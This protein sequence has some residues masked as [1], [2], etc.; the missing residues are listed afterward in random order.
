MERLALEEAA[1][2]LPGHAGAALS[3]AVAGAGAGPAAHRPAAVFLA[4]PFYLSAAG[5]CPW[6]QLRSRPADLKGADG[7]AVCLIKEACSF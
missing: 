7:L 2:R 1:G 6:A 3:A 4:E 5:S